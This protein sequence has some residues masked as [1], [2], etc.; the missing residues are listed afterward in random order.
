M[1]DRKVISG[2]DVFG[3]LNLG[4]PKSHK[5]QVWL[6]YWSWMFYWI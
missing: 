4:W 2:V 5:E 3:T 1:N 6:L